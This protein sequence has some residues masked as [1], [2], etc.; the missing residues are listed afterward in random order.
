MLIHFKNSF[1]VGFCNKFATR[2]LYFPPHFSRV[3]TLPGETCAMDMFDF[4][5]VTDDV[6]GLVQVQEN[7]PDI[8]VDPEVKINGA[9]CRDVLLT[10]QLLLV[11]RDI[12]GEFFIFKPDSVSAH[13]D[14]E[15]I[16]LLEWKTPAFI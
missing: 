5:R 4:Q 10:E 8:Y 3:T 15:T 14:C 16:S 9:Y 13:R 1:T 6:H 12:S 2:P 7:V 11:T